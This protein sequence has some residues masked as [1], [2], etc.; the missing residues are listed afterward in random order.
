MNYALL[1]QVTALGRGR[2]K[3]KKWKALYT[4]RAYIILRSRVRKLVQRLRNFRALVGVAEWKAGC[5]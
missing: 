2:Q 5:V 4:G 1:F 3:D